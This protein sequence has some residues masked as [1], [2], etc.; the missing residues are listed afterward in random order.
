MLY[1]YKN[2]KT[3]IMKKNLFNISKSIKALIG[4]INLKFVIS[5]ILLSSFI[6]AKSTNFHAAYNCQNLSSITAVAISED[7]ADGFMAVVSGF[8]IYTG[9]ETIDLVKLDNQFNVVWTKYLDF[10]SIDVEHIRA[11]D[12][13]H[14]YNNGGYAICGMYIIGSDFHGFL[15]KINNN[16]YLQWIKNAV[17]GNLIDPCKELRSVVIVGDNYISCGYSKNG[18]NPEK[19]F[20]WSVNAGTQ[21]TDWVRVITENN[22]YADIRLN[23]IGYN[24]DNSMIY[25]CGTWYVN[26]NLEQAVAASYDLSGSNNFVNLY[27]DGNVVSAKALA[28][29]STEIY[30]TGCIDNSNNIHMF[31]IDATT[32]N[33]N[34]AKN[35][36][37]IDIRDEV[38]DI[39]FYDDQLYY[40]GGVYVNN[41]GFNQG[42]LLQ[43]DI[44]GNFVFSALYSGI[45]STGLYD[46]I[47]FYKMLYRTTFTNPS[48]I[49][50]GIHSESVSF[51]IAETYLNYNSGCN[52]VDISTAVTNFN[53]IPDPII[54]VESGNDQ[55]LISNVY[56]I[57]DNT[58][59]TVL[60][61][62]PNWAIGPVEFT[63][64]HNHNVANEVE[65]EVMIINNQ[66][67]L[68]Y[69]YKNASYKLYSIDGKLL[70]FNKIND[71]FVIDISTFNQGIYLLSLQSTD[72]ILKTIKVNKQ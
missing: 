57:N 47:K 71:N 36:Y 37:D 4:I 54:T 18:S 32:G 68:P 53:P 59:E 7:G 56:S 62:S 11:Y 28:I 29:N 58:Y 46:D 69:K 60:C 64:N 49:K 26:G 44:A 6:P 34:T 9:Y 33:V 67:I 42:L 2:F 48:I 8:S 41:Y 39:L 63:A 35:I 55:P 38:E 51:Y 27:N 12:I 50:I 43:T 66:I 22:P 70:A 23:D 61:E 10:P 15:M 3:I 13:K 17:D 24:S 30:I 25:T 16:G 14:D 45:Y 52:D 19:G 1:F 20:I 31:A 72:N 21:I 40:T 65:A 5:L